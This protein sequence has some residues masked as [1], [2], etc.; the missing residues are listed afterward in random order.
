MIKFKFAFH[1]G[2]VILL[3]TEHAEND[4]KLLGCIRMI[5][6]HRRY[7]PTTMTTARFN[8]L[9]TILDVKAS[10]NHIPTTKH[11]T[12]TQDCVNGGSPSTALAQH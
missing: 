1:M 11:Q 5:E 4:I 8:L 10:E 3:G 9:L 6:V 7:R 2:V 12:S